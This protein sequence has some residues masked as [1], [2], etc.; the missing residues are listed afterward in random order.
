[1]RLARAILVT[2]RLHVTQKSGSGCPST[3]RGTIAGSIGNSAW[4]CGGQP[5]PLFTLSRRQRVRRN[6]FTDPANMSAANSARNQR[7]AARR[8]I[9]APLSSST[10]SPC[11]AYVNGSITR[12][13]SQPRGQRLH[14]IDRAA[15]EVQQ[16]VQDAEHRARQHRVV[17]ARDETRHHRHERERHHDD[18]Q[19]AARESAAVERCRR[20]PR[21]AAPRIVTIVPLTTALIVPARFWPSTSSS[22]V[23]GV[24]R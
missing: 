10:R 14:R 16:R 9:D 15:R 6:S 8:R 18:Q 1:M 24:T 2:V 7:P 21:P 11:T 12:D 17:H 20:R 22:F 4:S 5:D 19:H 13:P 23:I 3:S